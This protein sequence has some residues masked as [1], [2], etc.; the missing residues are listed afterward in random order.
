MSGTHVVGYNPDSSMA[1]Y[2]D[3]WPDGFSSINGTKANPC[4]SADILGD[5]REEFICKKNDGTALRI[6]TTII[7]S[8]FALPS[9]MSDHVYRMGVVWQNSSYNQPPHLGYYSSGYGKMKINSVDAN[10]NG[11]RYKLNTAPIKAVGNVYVPLEFLCEVAGARAVKDGNN[12][13]VTFKGKERELVV[14]ESCFDIRNTIIVP[15][16][17]MND[18]LEISVE[19]N[20]ETGEITVLRNEL[21]FMRY[22]TALLED[23]M[24]YEDECWVYIGEETIEVYSTKVV[25]AIVSTME[26]GVKAEII[27]YRQHIGRIEYEKP[28]KGDLRVFVW[29]GMH[30]VA[31]HTPDGKNIQ[32][33]KVKE[34]TASSEPEANNSANNSVDGDKATAWATFGEQN[35]V[36]DLG[37]VYS[38]EEMQI[39]FFKYEDNRVIPYEVHISED[40]EAWI[41]V[42]EGNSPVQSDDFVNISLEGNARY[43]KIIV[44][45]NNVNGWSRIS[46][47]KFYGTER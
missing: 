7:P 34:F 11:Q 28:E 16:N 26:N 40:N 27:P 6:Y 1:D 12:V 21:D 39:S 36:Y 22:E 14:G 9:P 13:T 8:E 33:L 17:E 23:Y 19:Y 45:G 38:F 43:V 18:L 32:K 4:L 31:K 46:E 5:W 29:E 37:K 47:V 15:F 10:I 25:D 20:M 42:S 3:A 44:K 30:P 35:I 2:F 41:K 24:P